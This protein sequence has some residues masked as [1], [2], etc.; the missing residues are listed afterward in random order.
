MHPAAHLCSPQ[1]PPQLR[2]AAAVTKS[3]VF[4]HLSLVLIS[5][6][7]GC[8]KR[9]NGNAT[10]NEFTLVLPNGIK[11]G[12]S[13]ELGTYWDGPLYSY[14][15]THSGSVIAE[16]SGE[17]RKQEIKTGQS[18]DVSYF[19]QKSLLAIYDSGSWIVWDFRN[20]AFKNFLSDL[21]RVLSSRGN[22]G[23]FSIKSFSTQ[24]GTWILRLDCGNTSPNPDWSSGRLPPEIHL[25][26]TNRGKHWT[27]EEQLSTP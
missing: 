10:T 19:Y 15:F 20:T 21:E 3:K 12:V 16:H 7:A 25:K 1:T 5:L 22:A 8:G 13:E 17:G 18:E 6:L 27:V 14:K 23:W 4:I 11:V 26:S 9:E 2:I 24:E